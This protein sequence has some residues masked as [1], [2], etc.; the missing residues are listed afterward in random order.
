MNSA[1]QIRILDKP[2]QAYLQRHPFGFGYESEMNRAALANLRQGL[3]VRPPAESL[4]PYMADPDKPDLTRD[5]KRS[6]H[7]WFERLAVPSPQRQWGWSGLAWKV[8]RIPRSARTVL[9]IGCGGGVELILIRALLPEAKL[10][11]IDFQD[12][13]P[14]TVKSALALRFVKGHFNDFLSQRGDS[15]DAVF[16]NHVLEHLY[17]PEATLGL[18]RERLTADGCLVAGLPMEGCDDGVFSKAMRRM[19]SN[20]AS[21]HPMDLGILD[22]GHAWKTNPVDLRKTL[23]ELGFGEVILHSRIMKRPAAAA[24]ARHT[25]VVLYASSF[26]I[27]RRC[28][29]LIFP[30]QPPDWVARGF[31]AAERRC[32]FGA[33]RLKNRFARE[34]LVVARV[35]RSTAN[36]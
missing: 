22:A 26:G 2:V 8:A 13:V 16:C 10:V 17:E 30:G 28:L 35:T 25:G 1:I 32:W 31:L 27:G 4:E 14:E 11:S 5:E 3:R 36:E 24:V 15:F 18:L 23:K 29:K 20:P 7:H 9:S 21:L 19:T 12:S 6:I 34:A 33:N